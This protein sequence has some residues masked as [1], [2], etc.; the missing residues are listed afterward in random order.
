MNNQ[1][2]HHSPKTQNNFF[3]NYYLKSPTKK[4]INIINLN[5]NIG[6]SSNN[7]HFNINYNNSTNYYEEISKAFNFIT[8][9]LKRK[10]S[11]IKELKIKIKELERQLNDINETN[12]MTFNN[13]DINEIGS[14]E[15]N[16][17]FSYSNKNN[18][19]KIAYNYI[20]NKTSIFFSN[21]N[22][23]NNNITNNDTNN[24]KIPNNNNSTNIN[25]INRV[26]NST[27][28]NKINNYRHKIDL[29]GPKLTNNKSNNTYMNNIP[30]NNKNK[31]MNTNTEIEE[32]K[33]IDM[34]RNTNEYSNEKKN[35]NIIRKE[36]YHI[37]A[38]IKYRNGSG[39]KIRNFQTN[40]TD[41]STGNDKIKIFNLSTMGRANSKNSKSTSITLSDEGISKSKAEI[42]NY[43]KEIKYKIDH[44]K[45]KKFVELIKILVKN[46]NTEQKNQI[47]FEIK[48]ILVDKNL[49]DKF[50]N[51]LK[52]K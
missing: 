11:Q 30:I 49:I 20:P 18:L 15:E 8:F 32:N 27:N 45:F 6:Q 34:N 12:I 2:R 51:I 26:K 19:K 38:N 40:E 39:N 48:S 14:S 7:F 28:I 3:N 37:N 33:K 17:N 50:E 43:L 47:I 23:K 36:P 52:I 21:V 25:I 46:K 24:N 42:K 31:S 9:I 4:D 35:I 41:T 13:K 1:I 44:D 5:N 16:Q 10:D 22:N 29:N